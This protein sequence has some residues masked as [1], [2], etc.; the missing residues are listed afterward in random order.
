MKL[1]RTLVTTAVTSLLASFALAQTLRRPLLRSGTGS[2]AS[3]VLGQHRCRQFLYL[4]RPQSVGLQAGT[5]N[6]CRL[7]ALERL[8]YRH[9][10]LQHPLAEGLRH[11][12]RQRRD[13]PLRGVQGRSRP[14]RLRRR[15]AA[16]LL[17]RLCR[18]GATK[19]DTTELYVAGTFK[20]F[21]LKY[22]HVVSKSIFGVANSRNSGYLDLTGTFPIMDNLTLTAR[23]APDCQEHRRRRHLHRRQA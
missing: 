22:S 3:A 11:Q 8:L 18:P 12:Q 2:R 9:L 15:R 7:R 6:R 16:V 4:S 20:M 13:R 19:P 10:G 23:G 1:K 5:A 17:H 14:D 21:T